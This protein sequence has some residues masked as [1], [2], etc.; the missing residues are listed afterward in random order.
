[1]NMKG[2]GLIAFVILFIFGVVITFLFYAYYTGKLA[3]VIYGQCIA[4]AFNEAD[5]IR[6]EIQNLK[7]QRPGSLS[8]PIKITFGGCIGSMAFI[9]DELRGEVDIEISGLLQCYEGYAAHIIIGP[10]LVDGEAVDSGWN[11]WERWWNTKK[12]KIKQWIVGVT[13]VEIM[14]FCRPLYSTEDRFIDLDEPMSLDGPGLNENSASYC[15]QIQKGAP[16]SSEEPD[17]GGYF[18]TIIELSEGMC[19][20]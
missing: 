2:I 7:S 15:L 9:N 16:V 8:D 1:M 13:G 17:E 6:A 11:F 4:D 18:N 3:E 20:S 10:R 5:K 19:T 14:N 12:L